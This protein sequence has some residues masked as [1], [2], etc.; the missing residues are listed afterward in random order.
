MPPKGARW[1]PVARTWLQAQMPGQQALRFPAPRGASPPPV[2]AVDG[3]LGPA[4]LYAPPG[5]PMQPMERAAGMPV[6]APPPAWHPPAPMQQAAAPPPQPRPRGRPPLLRGVKTGFSLGA[7]AGAARKCMPRATGC[8]T[9][10]VLFSATL[11]SFSAIPALVPPL[12]QGARAVAGL[13]EDIGSFA[14]AAARLGSNATDGVAILVA[15]LAHSSLSLST[16]AWRGVDLQNVSAH[17][18]SGAVIGDSS[19]ALRDFFNSSAGLLL[20]GGAATMVE[21]LCSAVDA[22]GVAVPVIVKRSQFF[23]GNGTYVEG[24]VE[25]RLLGSGHLAARWRWARVLFITA[26]S[27][28]V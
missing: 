9:T 14:G 13:A 23:E 3:G 8:L 15:T 25:V 19:G 11:A 28:F 12:A 21:E 16:E 22:V 18:E 17:V 20:L 24:E 2:H 7:W 1:D 5:M 6:G 27:N 4:A 26:W 10:W